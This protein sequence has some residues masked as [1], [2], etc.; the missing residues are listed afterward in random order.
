MHLAAPSL[1][2]KSKCDCDCPCQCF[3]SSSPR[4]CTSSS[5]STYPSTTALPPTPATQR[6]ATAVVSSSCTRQQKQRQQQRPSLALS[7]LPSLPH[8]QHPLDIL[9]RDAHHRRFAANITSL[10]PP[11]LPPIHLPTHPVPISPSALLVRRSP[12]P[13]RYFD[14]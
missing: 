4:R 6:A 5:S 11:C 2:G 8:L 14:N 12:A 1:N 9:D 13:F 7:L 10:L 3:S